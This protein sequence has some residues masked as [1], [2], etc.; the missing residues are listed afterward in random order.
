MTVEEAMKAYLLQGFVYN[1]ELL[2]FG[3]KNKNFNEWY[4][5]HKQVKGKIGLY[6]QLA[7]IN[8]ISALVFYINKGELE[9]LL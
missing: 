3:K 7:I 4:E 6:N 2:D 8:T 9:Q 1:G 5:K